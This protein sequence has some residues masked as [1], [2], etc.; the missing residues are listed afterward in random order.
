MALFIR[1]RD[2]Y[3]LVYYLFAGKKS[4]V[5]KVTV[6]ITIKTMFSFEQKPKKQKYVSEPLTTQIQ[7]IFH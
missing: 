4:Q 7:H 5:I 2:Y 3:L 6:K 1:K